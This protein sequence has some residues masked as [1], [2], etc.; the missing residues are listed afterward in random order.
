[1]KTLLIDADGLV[2]TRP[3]YFSEMYSEKYGVPLKIITEFFINDFRI[4]QTGKADLKEQLKP[5]LPKW[6]LEGTV[7]D[8]LNL[9][10]T[11]DVI[12]SQK[13]LDTIDH[14]RQK[15]FK[16][17]LASDQEKYRAEYIANI[18]KG[19]FDGMF[20]SCDLGYI[21]AE[22]EFF[23]EIVKKINIE[24]E[25][26]EFWDDEIENTQVAVN[27]GIKTKLYIDPETFEKSFND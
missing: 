14:L 6:K 1:M 2:I 3:K 4:C 24:P 7:E 25:N 12:L 18:L 8:F 15:G 26:I 21:K 5:Y 22:Q 27:L 19:H 17:Y 23:E 11:S 13:V 9:W 10:F 20:F 16:C